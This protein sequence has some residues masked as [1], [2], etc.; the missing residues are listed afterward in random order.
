MLSKLCF[1]SVIFRADREAEIGTPVQG[2]EKTHSGNAQPA[3]K[4]TRDEK[5]LALQELCSGFEQGVYGWDPRITVN[6]YVCK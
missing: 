3:A 6:W 2:T 4:N 1:W 5:D